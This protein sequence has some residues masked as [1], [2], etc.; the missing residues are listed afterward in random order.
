MSAPAAFNAFA[1]PRRD[2][3]SDNSPERLRWFEIRVGDTPA[4]TNPTANAVCTSYDTPTQS[5]Y[6][7]ACTSTVSGRY[8]V[9]RLRPEYAAQRVTGSL[10]TLCEVQAYGAPARQARMLSTCPC[11]AHM[12]G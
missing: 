1:D 11:C 5:I 10:L 4:S 8:L 2:S 6:S 9:V 3:F 7:L 12:A